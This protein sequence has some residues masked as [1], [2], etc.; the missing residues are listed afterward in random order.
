MGVGG[1]LSSLLELSGLGRCITNEAVHGGDEKEMVALGLLLLLLSFLEGGGR[2]PLELPFYFRVA[3][4]AAKLYLFLHDK[5]QLTRL[6][7]GGMICSSILRE[8][9]VEFPRLGG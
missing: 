1:G 5:P 8:L 3:L 7:V 2:K 6:S 9:A 4:D